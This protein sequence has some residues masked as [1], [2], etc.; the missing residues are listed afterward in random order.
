MKQIKTSL[1]TG[2]S[3]LAFC[4]QPA[5]AANME[6]QVKGAQAVG[7]LCKGYAEEIGRDSSHFSELNMQTIKIA[8]T[9]GYTDDFD[10]YENEVSALQE[11]LDKK[12]K[13]QYHSVHEIYGDWCRRYYEAFIKRAGG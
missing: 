13:G 6:E 7:G 10:N 8:E 5:I 3:L 12:L 11:I 2:L 4:F 9:L 1:L